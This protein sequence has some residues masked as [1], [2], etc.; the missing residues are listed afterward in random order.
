MK[1]KQIL[2][3][4]IA[5]SAFA[6][7]NAVIALDLP[8]TIPEGPYWDIYWNKSM[9]D[10]CCGQQVAVYELDVSVCRD[11]TSVEKEEIKTDFLNA[12][13]GH[14]QFI[15]DATLFYNC[16][17]YVFNDFE[18]WAGDPAQWEGTVSPCYYV[19]NSNG[20]AYR[21]G[22]SHSSYAGT[23]YAYEGKCGA[24]I[25]CEHDHTIYGT[26]SERWSQH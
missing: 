13:S 5:V 2:R 25:L 19:D 9:V 23:T 21:W 20:S 15:D 12:N 6:V 14:V 24:L 3:L 8:G 10:T 18:Y 22:G 4:I 26:H 11:F 17:S 16:H 7:C 1:R